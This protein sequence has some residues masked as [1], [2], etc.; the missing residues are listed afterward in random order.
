MGILQDYADRI[1]R[2][3]NGRTSFSLRDL[4]ETFAVGRNTLRGLA[5]SAQISIVKEG[6]GP[7]AARYRLEPCTIAEFRASIKA[8]DLSVFGPDSIAVKRVITED[9]WLQKL[10]KNLTVLE[11]M[12]DL[13]AKGEPFPAPDFAPLL[14]RDCAALLQLLERCSEDPRYGNDDTRWSVLA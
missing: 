11:T 12:L 2:E 5:S 1:Y 8:Q 3:V 10:Q 6:A 4:E 7:V 14:R 9:D 13:A